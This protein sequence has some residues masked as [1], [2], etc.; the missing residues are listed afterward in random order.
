MREM[1]TKRQRLLGAFVGER[2]DR[3]PISPFIW[4]NYANEY[5]GRSY[6]NTDEELDGAVLDIYRDFGFD[7]MLR[8]CT[9][10]NA[11]SEAALDSTDW[12]VTVVRE[13]ED[14]KRRREITLIKT[15]EAELREVREFARITE[16]EEVGAATEHF[17]KTEEDF[18]QFAKFQPPVPRYDCGRIRRA[19]E[20]LGDEGIAAPW[21]QGIFNCASEH[22]KL[23]DL[24]M[25]AYEAPEFY[26]GMM[27]H[28][29]R[30][31]IDTA[32][33]F[34]DAG[35]DVLCY[36]GNIANGT[37]VGPRFFEMNVMPYESRL[38]GAIQGRGCHVLY[39]NCGDSN[40][41][42]EIYNKTG[43]SGLET[44]TEPP[45]GDVD[46]DRALAV[47]DGGITIV[48]N[49]DQI[50]FLKT[51]NPIEVEAKVRRLVDKAKGRGNFILGTSDYLC[52]GTPR[53]NVA[54]LAEAGRRYG[55]Y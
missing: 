52:E 46:I 31:W 8:T 54:A 3:V 53:A 32:V 34:A 9:V 33:Q 27:E 43:F 38:I 48:G 42:F 1:M 44:L 26:A 13:Q 41:M 28:F 11:F 55:A 22:R 49:I 20:L 19:R 16:N 35:A 17:I 23:D 10:W 2:I 25:D 36:N 7:P 21:T 39:H 18:R 12:R 50:E 47:L 15:P 51:A 30:R 29:T 6:S 40:S 24:I 4:T 5:Y 45:Y 14:A 37:M